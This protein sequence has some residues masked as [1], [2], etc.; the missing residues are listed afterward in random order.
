MTR[1]I[2]DC[3]KYPSE[4][5]CTLT[6]VGEE[7]EVV[8]AASEHAASVHGHQDGPE[9]REQIKGMLEDEKVGV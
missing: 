6:I 1:K 7:D 3:R 4:T 9:L 5:D 8:R 2:A